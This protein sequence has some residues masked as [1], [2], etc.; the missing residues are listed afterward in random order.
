MGKAMSRLVWALPVLLLSGCALR[1][2][3]VLKEAPSKPP[4]CA[5]EV[6]QQGTDT[7][8]PYEKLCL[9]T[10]KLRSRATKEKALDE[11]KKQ[12]CT[13]GAD[14]ILLGSEN[15][16]ENTFRK[17]LTIE[18]TAIRWRDAAPAEPK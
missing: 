18:A 7:K 1:A 3:A 4:G 16:K 2:V 6:L 15:F 14:A 9:L 10:V 17:K 12:A 5:I 8:R 11:L 13:C